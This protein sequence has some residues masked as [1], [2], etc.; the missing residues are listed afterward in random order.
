MPTRWSPGRIPAGDR[1]LLSRP[2]L[3]DPR[4][5]NSLQDPLIGFFRVVGK[6]RKF[7]HVAVKVGEAHSERIYVRKLL[8]ELQSDLLRILPSQLLH[9]FPPSVPSETERL[10]RLRDHHD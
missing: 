6:R 4:H 2:V 1:L 3:L 9:L 8:I 7:G 5:L 10:G